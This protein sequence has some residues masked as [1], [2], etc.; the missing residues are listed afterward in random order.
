[1][2][3]KVSP[4]QL[5]AGDVLLYHGSGLIS[6]LI[7]KFDGSDYSH[8]ALYNGVAVVEAIGSGITARGLKES[9]AGAKYVDVYRFVSGDGQHH[10]GDQGYSPEPILETAAGFVATADRYAYEQILLLALLASTRRIPLISD[11]PFLQWLLRNVLDNAAELLSKLIAAGKEPMIC[12]EL[13][14]RCYTQSGP[15]YDLL[16]RGADTL[17]MRAQAAPPPALSASASPA[18]ATSH[19]SAAIQADLDTYLAKYAIA[20]G[21]RAS[22]AVR[23]KAISD[24]AAKTA[25]LLAA[26]NSPLAALAVADFVTPRDLRDSPDLYKFGTLES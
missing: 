17:A 4:T 13:V 15:Q 20:K 8:A 6:D 26:A 5:Q 12:S 3:T 11:I 22:A 9:V 10:L 25:P 7:R 16:I 21:R 23:P 19:D 18:T 1:M 24:G 14:Y 2:S